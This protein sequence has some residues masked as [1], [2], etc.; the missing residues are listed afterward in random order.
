MRRGSPIRRA[1]L[2]LSLALAPPACG[3]QE[4]GFYD[5]T[6]EVPGEAGLDAA[7][8]LEAEDAIDAAAYLD[9]PDGDTVSDGDARTDC[10]ADG[11]R[12]AVSCAGGTACPETEPVCTQPHYLCEPCRSN[13]D[14]DTVR[15]GPICTPSGAC[16]PECDPNHP[17]PQSHPHCDRSIGRCVASPAP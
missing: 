7:T 14:C 3:T 10:D 9:G 13:Q 1:T 8:S 17:C 6:P 11:S 15:T 4:W 16:A 12:C 2:A 5:P